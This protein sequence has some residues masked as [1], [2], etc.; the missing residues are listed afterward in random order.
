MEVKKLKNSKTIRV[1]RLYDIVSM[2]VG[3]IVCLFHILGV[4]VPGWWIVE[5]ADPRGSHLK[6]YFGVWSTKT[7][8]NDICNTEV[9]KMSQE[10]GM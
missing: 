8:Q 2:V 6:F 7:C 10:R 3:C 9:A 4:S 5:E 1:N